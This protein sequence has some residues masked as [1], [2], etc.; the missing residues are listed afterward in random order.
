MSQA[1]DIIRSQ[2]LDKEYLGITGLADFAKGAA[3]LAFG[4]DSSVIS[5]GRVST[6]TTATQTILKIIWCTCR[7]KFFGENALKY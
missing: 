1:E 2:N 3:K 5:D 7:M 4:D 6:Y